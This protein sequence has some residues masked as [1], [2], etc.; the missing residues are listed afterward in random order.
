MPLLSP[1][2]VIQFSFPLAI[3]SFALFKALFERDF[4]KKNARFKK[5]FRNWL[6]TQISSFVTDLQSK[7]SK[8]VTP[9]EVIQEMNV[10]VQKQ[11][12][13][14]DVTEEFEA[15]DETSNRILYSLGGAI[16][17]GF[18]GVINPGVINGAQ[19]PNSGPL[20]WGDLG[21]LLLAL[22]TYFI[23]RYMW[24]FRRVSRRMSKVEQ[25]TP[26]EKIFEKELSEENE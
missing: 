7:V 21:T 17:L 23:F 14:L 5:A 26:F 22:G 16:L 1:V 4:E 8:K 18:F 19:N 11:A 24:D 6:N 20:Y 3:G 25:G 12:N 2:E 15:L 13:L 10:W 9:D